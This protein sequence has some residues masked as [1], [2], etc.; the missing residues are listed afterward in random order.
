MRY[1]VFSTVIK[2]IISH[3][4]DDCEFSQKNVLMDIFESFYKCHHNFSFDSSLIS[5]W[6]NG[7]AALSPDIKQ[8]YF[9]DRLDKITDDF[10]ENLYHR[11]VD[12]DIL[13]RDLY[14]L[15]TED[16]YISE[17]KRNEIAE[18]YP[19]DNDAD[20]IAF[21]G[22]ILVYVVRKQQFSPTDSPITT[23]NIHDR[24]VGAEVPQP[25]KHFCGRDNEIS[26]L[27]DILK[28]NTKVFVCG[29][30][31]IGKSEFVKAY[32]QKYR[33]EYHG[34][35]YFNYTGDLKSMVTAA[36]FSDD[37]DCD[38]ETLFRIHHRF[39]HNLGTDVLIIIDNF[40]VSEQADKFLPQLMHYNCRIVFTTRNSFECGTSYTLSEIDDADTLYSMASEYYEDAGENKSDIMDII[41]VVHHHT[42]AVE[43]SA[44]LLQK[45]LL[46][47]SELLEKLRENS[48]DPGS[49]DKVN[50]KKDGTSTKATYYQHLSKLCSLGL[51]DDDMKNVMRNMVFVPESGMRSRRFAKWLGMSDMNAVND[52]IELGLVKNPT[53][54][55]ITLHPIIRDLTVRDITPVYSLC[56]GFIDN[57][58]ELCLN[59][60]RYQDEHIF[61]T[62]TVLNIMRYVG[63]DDMPPYIMFIIDA[64]GFLDSYHEEYAMYY[65]AGELNNILNDREVGT[66]K[67]RALLYNYEARCKDVFENNVD[68]AI[69]IQKKALKLI[70][71]ITDMGCIA[72]LYMN[73][74]VLYHDKGSKTKASEYMAQAIAVYEENNIVTADYIAMKHN[75]A[76]LLAENGESL[77]A[78]TLLMDTAHI[79]IEADSSELAGLLFDAAVIDARMHFYEESIHLFNKSFGEYAKFLDEETLNMRK[80]AALYFLNSQGYTAIDS[81][82]FYL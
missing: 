17:K 37:T 41:E 21:I 45:G 78:H 65:A 54:D 66:P 72:N 20:K 53:H 47:S 5:R 10:R 58:H 27:H 49:A 51:L 25:C 50:I 81:N 73:M 44:R 15:L 77:K 7:K 18:G 35:L 70:P 13:V 48:A 43:L 57:I 63:K 61:I 68:R 64:L 6:V 39:F 42:L 22:R 4:Q 34:I 30:P 23:G 59:V 8:Y 2:T 16:T 60:G 75:Y 38:H 79:A 33:R 1:C 32:A 82:N 80:Q 19:Y 40:N 28:T 36:M 29:I 26:E 46:T 71:K 76:N 12:P 14:E 67:D 55:I 24:V 62:D 9:N 52:L 74:G 3:L 31:G 11:M 56:T 69:E